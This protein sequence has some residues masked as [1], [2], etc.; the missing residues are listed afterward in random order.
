MARHRLP[1]GYSD[2]ILT[3]IHDLANPTGA[4]L[5]VLAPPDFHPREEA[6]QIAL[7]ADC[8]MRDPVRMD[9]LVEYLAR[10]RARPAMNLARQVGSRPK[11]QFAG[12][13]VFPQERRIEAGGK[14]VRITPMEIEFVQLLARAPG[15]VV[16][17]GTLYSE[18]LER[19]FGGDTSNMRV[20]FAKVGTS[21]NRIGI[22]I[23]TVVQV[24]PKTGYHYLPPQPVQEEPSRPRQMAR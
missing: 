17:Y 3:L 5:V 2:D 13:T 21:F 4:R 15:K 9:V 11:F 16:A 20:L 19:S 8:V 12:A 6:R 7:G 18:V 23:R 10:F 24:I 1:D 22:K 14:S